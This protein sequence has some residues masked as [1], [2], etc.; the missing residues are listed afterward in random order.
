MGDACLGLLVRKNGFMPADGTLFTVSVDKA[1]KQAAVTGELIAGTIAG[2][3]VEHG[4][5]FTR[6]FIDLLHFR[7][8]G[9]LLRIFGCRAVV[10]WG[11]IVVSGNTLI[12]A[13]L[14]WQPSSCQGA[15]H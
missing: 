1:I 11:L 5:D 3:L 9:I 14:L 15:D 10:R 2:Q 13:P 4:P 6:Q 12:T 8:S 7:S